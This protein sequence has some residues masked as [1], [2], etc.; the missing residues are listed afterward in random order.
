MDATAKRN[1]EAFI[2]RRFKAYRANPDIGHVSRSQDMPL[3]VFGL[4]VAGACLAPRLMDGQIVIVEPRLPT[5]GDLAVVWVKG[6]SMPVIKILRTEIIG[7]PHHPQS[8]LVSSIDME[9]LSPPGRLSIWADKVDCI[10]RVHSIIAGG[11]KEPGK[12]VPTVRPLSKKITV[13]SGELPPIAPKR[14][15]RKST[16]DRPA[17]QEQRDAVRLEAI[18]AE[19]DWTNEEW[20]ITWL[21]WVRTAFAIIHLDDRGLLK[22]G[23]PGLIKDGAAPGLL[24]WLTR[25][26]HHL[27]ALA[28]VLDVALG[29]AFLVLER[30][31]YSPD[32]PPP[33]SPVR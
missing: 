15:S 14:R 7:F 19:F 6:Q 21:P 20:A 1:A 2:A 31:G 30:H 5:P 18:R 24:E 11:S 4:R 29:R 17:T 32:N 3:G 12:A 26:K 25:S 9:Q 28:N 33:D 27:E 10:A 8:E 13:P 23:I 22:E 16:K